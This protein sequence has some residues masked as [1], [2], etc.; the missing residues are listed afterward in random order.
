MLMA[1]RMGFEVVPMLQRLL[2]IPAHRQAVL[3]ADMCL[4]RVC[5]SV[6]CCSLGATPWW[7]CLSALVTGSGGS[8]SRAAWWDQGLSVAGD[9][10][11][12][13]LQTC[14]STCGKHPC[15]ALHMSAHVFSTQVVS[16][17]TSLVCFCVVVW[18]ADGAPVV[19]A[20]CHSSPAAVVCSA[21]CCLPGVSG[22]TACV[23]S[24]HGIS[25]QPARRRGSIS[26]KQ[27]AAAATVCR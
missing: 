8:S 26:T 20:L 7:H 3:C 16:A 1:V 12:M 21:D 19:C 2:V 6:S 22:S 24:S 25:A 11:K 14:M 5:P 13:R 23:S 15:S 17:A 4:G 10:V 9:T 18:I 27:Q